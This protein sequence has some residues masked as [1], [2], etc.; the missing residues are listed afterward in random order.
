MQNEPSNQPVVT[1]VFCGAAYPH[2]T[3]TH[4][5][6]VLVEHIKVCEK[7]PLRAAEALNA[8]YRSIL[9]N[10]LGG[11]VDKAGLE[12]IALT[13]RL[14]PAPAEDK[15]VAHLAKWDADNPIPRLIPQV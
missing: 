9:L 1:C 2:D 8:R 11:P 6:E 5:A 3:P 4:G 10:M 13:T 12:A 14:L 7:H 15:A